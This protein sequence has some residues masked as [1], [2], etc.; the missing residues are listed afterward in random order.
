MKE[1]MYTGCPILSCLPTI[2]S[3]A[4]TTIASIKVYVKSRGTD[5]KIGDYFYISQ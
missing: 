3:S 1:N 2:F 4:Q 5:C